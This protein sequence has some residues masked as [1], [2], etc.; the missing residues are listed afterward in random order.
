MVCFERLLPPTFTRRGVA[1]VVLCVMAPLAIARAA[2]AAPADAGRAS[3]DGLYFPAATLQTETDEYTSY[4]LLAP[5][6]Q[7]FK[8][9]YEVAAA[10]AGARFYYNPIR[11]GSAASDESVYDAMSGAR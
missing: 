9:R 3:A 4:D 8:I 6:T 11:K 1:S 7:S 5:R 10:T 2:M